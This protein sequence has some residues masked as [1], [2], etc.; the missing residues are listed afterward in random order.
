MSR[1]AVSNESILAEL[2]LTVV[3]SVSIVA[4]LPVATPVTVLRLAALLVTVSS[5]V[6]KSATNDE[7]ATE[8][9]A[10]DV[11]K[12]PTSDSSKESVS[13][14]DEMSFVLVD[15]VVVNAAT[16][17]F[18]VDTSEDRVETEQSRCCP[19]LGEGGGQDHTT[20]ESRRGLDNCKTTDNCV[21]L[22]YTCTR[23]KR[24]K[25]TQKDSER[26]EHRDYCDECTVRAQWCPVDL[27]RIPIRDGWTRGWVCSA[28]SLAI[29]L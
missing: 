10:T 12:V 25:E 27:Y 1:V 2:V 11:C 7:M 28:L 5:T 22:Q 29:Y 19:L 21:F 26:A 17:A 18:V 8:L 14:I 23:V 13:W 4:A 3:D 20:K 16:A 24:Q 6:C 15:T 9:A